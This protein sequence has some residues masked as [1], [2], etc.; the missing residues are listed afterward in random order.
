MSFST[1]V[2]FLIFNRPDL[3]QI[4]FE[5]IAKVK[6]KQLFVVADGPRFHAEA[7]K[8][9]RARAVIEQVD[10]ECDV[11]TNF[12]EKNLGCGRRPAS[13]IDWVFSR[14]EEAIFLED[15]CL[16]VESFFF[17]CQELLERYRD[18]HRIM[19]IGGNNFQSGKKRS[20]Y[21][22]HFSRYSGCWGWASWRRA[23]K[24]FDYKMKTWPEFKRTGMLEMVCKDAYEHKLWT[25]LFDSMYE[26]PDRKDIWDYQWKYA[27]WSQNG[28]A[29]EPSVN[30]VANI[31][32]GR[33][34]ASHTK[35]YDPLLAELSKAQD[36]WEIRH[37]P[38][39]VRHSDADNHIFDSFIRHKQLKENDTLLGK[40][41]RGLSTIREKA[42]RRFTYNQNWRSDHVNTDPH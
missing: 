6:P 26:N 21:S 5:A 41:R 37:P 1:P 17:F 40:L 9:E 19:A 13:G 16:P 25:K 28:L 39:V 7:E 8:C 32:L 3:T 35:G 24:Y 23:W 18:D 27:C 20:A 31:G 29:I 12:S 33:S 4:V 15:D 22:Y 10:W 42:R 30:L 2:A 14:V 38:F 34:D 11:L 36:L